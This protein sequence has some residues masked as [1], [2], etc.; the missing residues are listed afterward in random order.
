MS[1]QFRMYDIIDK[2]KRGEALNREEIAYFIRGYVSG[3]IPDYQ[4]SALLMAICFMGMTENETFYLTEE[5]VNSGKVMDLSAVNGL[6]LDKHST[7]GVGDKTSLVL[8][9]MIAAV[10]L[11]MPKASGRG[12]GHTGG[13]LDKLESIPGFRVTLSEEEFIDQVNSI[14]LAIVGQSAELAP[15][16]K[17][18][19]ALR[20]ATCT[21][22][23]IPLI[24]SSIM[25]KKLADGSDIQLLDVKFGQG[26]FMKTIQDAR[27]LAHTMISIGRKAGKVTCAELTSMDQPLGYEIGNINEVIEAVDTLRGKGPKDLLDLCLH[28]GSILLKLA[29]AAPSLEVA[30]R[31]LRQAIDSGDAYRSFVSMVRNQGGDVRY[32]ED[33]SLFPTARYSYEVKSIADGYVA[34][35]NTY[36]LGIQA[37]RL[38]AGRQTA[39]DTID[40]TAGISLKKK[41]GDRVRRDE[42][43]AVLHSERSGIADIGREVLADFTIRG[44]KPE[45]PPLIAETIYN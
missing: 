29:N 23:S 34:E 32:I 2:K 45:V 22:D 11:K 16:D 9:P 6:K 10:N 28:S 39:T 5:M 12:L 37:M 8:A 7:G 30:E 41:V 21:V 26:A 1:E 38:G 15:A 3:E 24:A 31:R 25:S 43:L 27:H 18:L 17:K 13:T 19:Y 40:H 4:A 33:T 42:V 14:N 35:M 44:E 20:D 36:D